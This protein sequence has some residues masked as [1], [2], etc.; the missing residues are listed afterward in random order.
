MILRKDLD[1]RYYYHLSRLSL[2][3]TRDD[4]FI[5]K[6]IGGF[7][8]N[9]GREEPSI[10]RTCVSDSIIHCLCAI[11]YCNGSLNIYRTVN[12]ITSYHPYDV[13]D[14]DI[15]NERWIL[16]PV[17]FML[18]GKWDLNE[19]KII[20]PFND[21]VGCKNSRGEQQKF[22]E[23]WREYFQSDPMREIQGLYLKFK[24]CK[25]I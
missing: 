5:L 21:I 24:D 23:F 25:R 15:T 9:R 18:A 6:P 11:P 13:N 22:I 2:H 19:G 1:K 4:P 16:H 7:T 8:D 12:R 20:Y 10:A 3:E 17:Q 14:S